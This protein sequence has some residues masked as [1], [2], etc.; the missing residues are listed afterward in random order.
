[1]YIEDGRHGEYTYQPVFWNC[2]SIWNRRHN[3]GLTTHEEPVVGATNFAYVKIKNRGTLAA[4][5]VI[6]K[7][8]H[9]DPAIGLVYPN[10]WQP[11][12]TAQLAAPTWRRTTRPKSWPLRVVPTQIGHG[13]CMFMV[14]PP[15]AT[16][17]T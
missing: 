14:A 13:E 15:P 2:Q 8:F 7:A 5:G 11:M 16:P 17:A 10:D 4:T 1:V 12:T 9:A 6:V 3:D